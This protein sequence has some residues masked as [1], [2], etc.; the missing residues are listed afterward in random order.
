MPDLSELLAN[1]CWVEVGV[2]GGT[3]QVAYRPS[4]TS[5][6]EQA[7]LMKR[8]R[9][10]QT[11]EDIDEED[12]AREMAEVVCKVVVNWDLTD[13]GEPLEI[14]PY[15]VANAIPG[16]WIDPIMQAVGND[17]TRAQE[18]KKQLNANSGAISNSRGKQEAARNGTRSSKTQST[19]A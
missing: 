11:R 17:R 4:A 18:E 5:L 15:T 14:T 6:S 7:K 8:I 1:E 10:L 16:A 3:F 9:E 13:G 12:A 2:D 19:W